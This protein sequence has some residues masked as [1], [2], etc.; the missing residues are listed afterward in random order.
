[1]KHQLELAHS[2]EGAGLRLIKAALSQIKPRATVVGGG[3]LPRQSLAQYSEDVGH[4]LRQNL[5]EI[6]RA[7]SLAILMLGLY[8][9]PASLSCLSAAIFSGSVAFLH[10]P[11]C[12][13]MVKNFTGQSLQDE[14][15]WLKHLHDAESE[16]G[17]C[18]KICYNNETGPEPLRSATF[19][20]IDHSTMKS[21]TTSRAH[22]QMI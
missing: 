20:T 7:L 14:I 16:S 6:S 3:G 8:T 15:R 2:A 18:E 9:G 12:G 4:H 19:S 1:V 5:D 11:N 10:S 13:L 22:L 17:Q 21:G